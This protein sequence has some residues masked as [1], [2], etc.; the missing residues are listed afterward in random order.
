MVVPRSERPLS[1]SESL[2]P[3]DTKATGTEEKGAEARK[4]TPPQGIEKPLSAEEQKAKEEKEYQ[5]RIGEITSQL[6]AARDRY[7]AASGGSGG[8]EPTLL[9][10]EEAIKART[11]DLNSRLRDAQYNPSGPRDAGGVK[12]STPSPFTGAP[13]S[14]TE[15][16]PAEV[17]RRVD[18]P[19]PEYTQRERE[20]S[21][22]R[23]QIS[24]LE[25]ERERLI[26]EMRRKNFNT[27]SVFLD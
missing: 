18:S 12:L 2:I 20:L 27:G 3:P 19:P 23:S 6:K 8:K 14:V 1:P 4:D 7:S 22:L 13:P 9:N 25:S 26:Q 21:D 11:E 15:L 10:S 24:R 16:P 17:L 5:K